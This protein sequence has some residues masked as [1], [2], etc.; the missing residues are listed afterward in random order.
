MAHDMLEKRGTYYPASSAIITHS[1]GELKNPTLPVEPDKTK[2]KL[3]KIVSWAKGVQGG[4]K[5][6]ENKGAE[7]PL[8]DKRQWQDPILQGVGAGISD[9]ASAS[10]TNDTKKYITSPRCAILG[11]KNHT[12]DECPQKHEHQPR[13]KDQPLYY[14]QFGVPTYTFL[15]VEDE[16]KQLEREIKRKQD[17]LSQMIF[18]SDEELEENIYAEIPEVCAPPRPTSDFPNRFPEKPRYS[19]G[20]EPDRWY[21]QSGDRR[22]ISKME[23]EAKRKRRESAPRRQYQETRRPNWQAA[24]RPWEQYPRTQG[25]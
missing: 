19:R 22:R 16:I 15:P 9:I 1:Y 20:R 2:N 10:T 5:E 7:D 17:G 25:P 13:S 6:Q 23:L 18:T 24:I 21:Y 4:H 11:H 12:V 14:R 8:G 3:T